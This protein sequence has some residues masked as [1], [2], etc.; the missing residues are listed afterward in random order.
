MVQFFKIKVRSALATPLIE[1]IQGIRRPETAVARKDIPPQ[2]LLDPDTRDYLAD[3]NRLNVLVEDAREELTA[4]RAAV[5][6]KRS[7]GRRSTGVAGFTVGGPDWTMGMDAIDSWAKE[8]LGFIV[9]GLGP[10]SRVAVASLHLDEAR[11]HLHVLAMVADRNGKLGMKAARWGFIPKE[12]HATIQWNQTYT[13]ILD[14]YHE[15]VSS[16]YDIGRGKTD[17]VGKARPLDRTKAIAS[18][19]KAD[20]QLGFANAV[21]ELRGDYQKLVDAADRVAEQR[22]GE[23]RR[24]KAAAEEVERTARER[25]EQA[26]AQLAAA[27]Q[28]EQDAAAAVAAAQQREKAAAQDRIDTRAVL[29]EA[30]NRLA[31]VV[32]REAEVVHARNV[33]KAESRK[34]SARDAKVRTREHAQ[35]VREADHARTVEWDKAEAERVNRNQALAQERLVEARNRAAEDRYRFGDQGNVNYDLKM[36]QAGVPPKP[37]HVIQLENEAD[38]MQASMARA[39]GKAPPPRRNPEP[40]PRIPDVREYAAKHVEAVDEALNEPLARPAPPARPARGVPEKID[41][42]RR[43]DTGR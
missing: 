21:R 2:K 40:M 36:K 1:H 29:V 24:Q 32:Q 13:A 37:D 43:R 38:E 15:Q 8:T 30:Q 20:V 25:E 35:D 16:R 4:S 26:A 31:N 11:P 22:V 17:R 41:P 34:L 5:R 6:A 27:A 23:A 7:A 14:E 33:N 9:D 18:R 19:T 39:M 28:R 3:L 42:A 12:K 10:R